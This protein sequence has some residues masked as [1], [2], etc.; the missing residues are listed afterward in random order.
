VRGND[1]VPLEPGDV[2]MAELLRGRGYRTSLVGKW[3]L[4]EAGS[5]GAP[6]RK[7]FDEFFGYLNQRHAHNHF[8]SHL[9]RGENKVALANVVPDEDAEGAG[10]ASKRVQ[11][12]HDLFTDEALAFVRRN[13]GKPFFLYLAYTVPHANNE[14][15][16]RGMEVPELGE[17]ATR[18]WPE[19]QKGHAAMVARL[20][21]DVGRLAA[22]LRELG[23]ERDTLLLFTS[24]NGPHREGGFDPEA[25]RS[26]GPLRGIKRDLYEGGI[27]VPMIARWPGHVPAGRT[28]DAVW[29]AADL[30]PTLAALTGAKAPAGL[31]GLDVSPVLLGRRADLPERPLYWEF[32]EK[33]F[34][35]ALRLG[36]WKAVLRAGKPLELYDLARDQSETRDVA[37]QQT[38]VVARMRDLIRKSHTA[39]PHWKVPGI[40]Q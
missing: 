37:A 17:Y 38:A 1:R 20:D 11:M 21:R 26:S 15:K 34:H 12:S 25:A 40:D 8:P 36:R 18:P 16:D 10:V 33:G 39:S 22:T 35:Q 6:T 30:L 5:S 9:W 24:D 28:S 3:G 4:G 13:A 23:I 31:D 19:P 27:R 14:A 32:H 7:G 2:T 29:W